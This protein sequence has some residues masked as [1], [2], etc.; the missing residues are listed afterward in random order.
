MPKVNPEIVVWA[1]ESAGL[2]REDAA[3]RLGLSLPRLVQI[4]TGEGDPTDVQLEK[5]ARVFRRPI[6]SFYLERPPAP[7]PRTHDFRMAPDADPR[8]E[9]N[10][11]ALVRDLSARQSIVRGGLEELEEAYGVELVGSA[12]GVELREQLAARMSVAIGFDLAVFRRAR[13]ISRAFAYLRG[14]I[15]ARRIFVLLVGDLGSHHTKLPPSAFRGIALPDPVAPMIVVND[16]DSPAAWTFT[17]LHELG[18][19]LLGQGGISGYNGSSRVER[20]C[21][22]AAGEMLLPRRE[23]EA[24][25]LQPEPGEGLAEVVS[26]LAGDRNVSRTMLAYNLMSAGRIAADDYRALAARF[27]R[28]RAAA[29]RDRESAPINPYVVRRHRI[30]PAL[31]ALVDRMVGANVLSS[32]KAGKVLAVRPTAVQQMARGAVA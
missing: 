27:A 17:A 22:A 7:A 14:L 11:A 19:I 9:A 20:L 24:L 8:A 25:R 29:R 2:T 16:N 28:E 30:G 18:H 31:S 4:E 15:E 21:D 12:A 5:I 23:V 32:S 6:L 3:A 1:R 10:L 26:G 13:D